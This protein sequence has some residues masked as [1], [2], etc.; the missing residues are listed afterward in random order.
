[1]PL[2]NDDGSC[3]AGVLRLRGLI[4]KRIGPL[5]LRMTFQWG[6]NSGRHGSRAAP[7]GRA[8]PRSGEAPNTRAKQLMAEA[9][10]AFPSS[11]AETRK[12][13]INLR[14]ERV[15]EKTFVAVNP[16]AGISHHLRPG[17]D[18]PGR[19]AGGTVPV[20]PVTQYTTAK[21]AGAQY[22]GARPGADHGTR[23]DTEH[24]KFSR[25]RSRQ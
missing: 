19:V 12:S 13:P 1:M 22:Y 17:T 4:R 20:K 16:R 10:V 11:R 5:S 24:G 14:G 25:H 15:Y 6:G 23:P 8:N 18:R 9:T 2:S 21:Y 3:R 7:R